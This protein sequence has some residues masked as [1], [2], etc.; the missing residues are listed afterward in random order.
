MN[1]TKVGAGPKSLELRL[2][3]VGII[4]NHIL[5]RADHVRP[6]SRHRARVLFIFRFHPPGPRPHRGRTTGHGPGT[7]R[8]SGLCAEVWWFWYRSTVVWAWRVLEVSSRAQELASDLQP[9]LRAEELW[10][11]NPEV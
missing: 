2:I 5:S 8:N 10:E 3:S 4:W 11:E 6:P 9:V 1:G 7:R